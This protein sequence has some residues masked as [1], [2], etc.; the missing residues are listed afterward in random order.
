MDTLTR[1][2]RSERMSRVRCKDT[3]PEMVVR[4]LVYSLGY[5]YRLHV[6]WLPGRP[7][8]VFSARRKVVFVHGC[9]WHRH[10]GCSNCRLPKSRLGFWKPKL[11]A[12]RQRDK[13]NQNRL[14]RLGWGTL[15]VWEC[16]IRNTE[17]VIAKI[18][19]FLESK[20]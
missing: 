10:K 19:R 11:E 18:T 8:M 20:P 5:R 2:Q 9:F 7:D 3:K 1:A 12:N 14:R 4:R 15:V 16:E 13:R 17:K 6:G